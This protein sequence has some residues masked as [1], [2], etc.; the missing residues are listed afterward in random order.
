MA[1]AVRGF[2]YPKQERNIDI[3]YLHMYANIDKHDQRYIHNLDMNSFYGTTIT[4]RHMPSIG[5]SF[6]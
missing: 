2:A 1:F 3:Y 4:K 6:A 5:L